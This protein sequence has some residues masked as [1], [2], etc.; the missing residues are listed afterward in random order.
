[1]PCPLCY[2][3]EVYTLFRVMLLY[4]NVMLPADPGCHGVGL[5][6][7]EVDVQHHNSHTYAEIENII[8]SRGSVGTGNYIRFST[9]TV[10]HM[11]R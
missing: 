5:G 6:G 8:L 3:R 9:T 4:M 2:T 10:T 7:P 11:L 1:M